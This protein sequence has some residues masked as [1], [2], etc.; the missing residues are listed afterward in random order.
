[1]RCAY[2]REQIIIYIRVNKLPIVFGQQL[3]IW[4]SIITAGTNTLFDV[5]DKSDS[6]SFYCRRGIMIMAGPMD[7]LGGHV[8]NKCTI[9]NFQR[10]G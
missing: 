2:G 5:T 8:R 9:N 1:M 6:A 3:M 4:I 10:N 7:S